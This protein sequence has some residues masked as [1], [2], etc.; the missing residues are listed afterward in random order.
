MFLKS[1]R[2]TSGKF[3]QFTFY[4][5]VLWQLWT[6]TSFSSIHIAD[7]NQAYLEPELT[8]IPLAS[9]DLNGSRSGL[10]CMCVMKLQSELELSFRESG[11]FQFS[12]IA[13]GLYQTF[14]MA[15]RRNELD[16]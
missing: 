16:G 8:Q 12:S 13:F 5:F 7:F 9:A 1:S 2:N 6:P 14:G 15:S 10:S 11:T 4:I 3:S